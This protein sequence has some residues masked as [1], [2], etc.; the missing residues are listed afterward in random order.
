M[1]RNAGTLVATSREQSTLAGPGVKLDALVGSGRDDGER[2]EP[3]Q[4][5]PPPA[6]VVRTMGAAGGSCAIG[7]EPPREYAALAPSGPIA[8]SYGCGD[9]FAA[10]FTFALARGDEPDA[11]LEL[12]ARCGAACLTGRGPYRGQ[13]SAADLD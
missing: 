6:I 9:S 1:A 5:V 11:A 3:G 8:D 12:A 13:L 2:Y 4:L 7:D 10:A